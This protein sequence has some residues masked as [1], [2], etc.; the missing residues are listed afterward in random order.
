MQLVEQKIEMLRRS[1]NSVTALLAGSRMLDEDATAELEYKL[2]TIAG[3]AYA[4][5]QHQVEDEEHE[6]AM[7][8]TEPS[9]SEDRAPSTTLPSSTPDYAEDDDFV[10][11][12]CLRLPENLLQRINPIVFSNPFVVGPRRQQALKADDFLA[13]VC[14]IAVFN[15][16]LAKHTQVLFHQT[17]MGHKGGNLMIE[18]V[19]EYYLQALNLLN[20]LSNVSTDGTLVMVYLATLNN[21]AEVHTMLDETAEALELQ[22][23]LGS[24][25]LSI[26]PAPKSSVYQH[27]CSATMSYSCIAGMS[28][29]ESN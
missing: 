4:C 2:F 8:T 15:L 6:D 27:F 12:K 3:S 5:L 18:R 24:C 16:A 26:P 29:F 17:K 7:D 21:L 23:C 28:V 25:L 10:V 13:S 11:A 20:Q 1:V 14:A 19:K 22:D 9:P